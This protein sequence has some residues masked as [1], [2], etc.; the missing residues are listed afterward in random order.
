[1][2]K[3]LAS[4]INATRKAFPAL[5]RDAAGLAG[6]VLF[7]YGTWLVYRP[8]GFMVAGLALIAAAWLS[9]RKRG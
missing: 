4:A 8:A 1:M 6:A 2:R 3:T 7:V 5:A 9:A